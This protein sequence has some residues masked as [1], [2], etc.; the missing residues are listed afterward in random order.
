MIKIIIKIQTYEIDTKYV[1]KGTK[2]MTFASYR[3]NGRSFGVSYL[4][5]YDP[6]RLVGLKRAWKS[7]E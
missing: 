2:G 6:R 3:P 5:T 1:G 4:K 7:K